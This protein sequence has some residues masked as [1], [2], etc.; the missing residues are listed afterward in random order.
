MYVYVVDKIV[1]RIRWQSHSKV[2]MWWLNDLKKTKKLL[3]LSQKP[4]GL[5]FL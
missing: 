2:G 1:I 5:K 3:L 4:I